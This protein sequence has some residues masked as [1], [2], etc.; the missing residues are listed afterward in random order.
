VG[1]RSAGDPES[2]DPSEAPERLYDL[3]NREGTFSRHAVF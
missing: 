3:F 1:G 2:L